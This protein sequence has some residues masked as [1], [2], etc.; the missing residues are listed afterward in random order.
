MKTLLKQAPFNQQSNATPGIVVAALRGGSGKTIFSV[1]IIAA[2]KSLGKTVAPFKKGPDYIDAGWLALAAGRPCYNL[3][4]FLIDREI[5]LG[6]YHTHTRDADFTLIEGNRGL[7]DCI[8]TKGETSTAE[9]AK[10][11]G[12]PVILCIDG[13][14]TTRTMAAVVGGI[15]AFDPDVR[16]GGVVLNRVAGKRHQSILTRSIEEYTGIPVLGAVPKLKKQRFPERHMGLVP[17]PEHSWAAPAIDAIREVAENHLDIDRIQRLAAMAEPVDRV[18]LN[19]STTSS[20]ATKNEVPVIGIV[21]DSA[22]QFYYPENLEALESAGAHLVF[23]SPLKD[24]SLPSVDALYI[25]G[26]FPETHG[27]ELEANATFRRELKALAEGG[28]PVYAECG[29]L[30]YLGEGLILEDGTYEM[31]GVLP[32]VFGFSKRPQGHGYTIVRVEGENP[33]FEKGATLLGHE[34]HYSSVKEWK[35]SPQNLAFSMQ[36]GSGFIDG[37]DGVCI[38][39]VLATY[40]HIHALGTPVWAK[41]LVDQARAYRLRC[42]QH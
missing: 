28:L 6:S 27:R 20:T 12:L 18:R 39:N 42:S 33:Y 8:D 7:Y 25:G 38:N 37:R 29:G 16:I 34:F 31:A 2:L 26:G 40:T 3:D 17:T 11:L 23:L 24:K 32:V 21:R 14:K 9:L 41:A 13:T 36:R 1:G 10:L 19:V 15:A 30:M 4:S 22:F 5:L 35:G